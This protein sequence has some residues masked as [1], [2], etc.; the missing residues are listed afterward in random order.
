MRLVALASR[1]AIPAIYFAREF[2][3]AGGLISYGPSLTF[4]NRQVGALVGKILKGAA[5]DL[6]VQRS[7]VFEL[8][9][10]MKTAQLLGVTVPQ[11]LLARAAEVIE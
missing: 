1:H 9:I 4:A 8:L 11:S 5:T 3:V 6:P 2:T 7:T 10:N